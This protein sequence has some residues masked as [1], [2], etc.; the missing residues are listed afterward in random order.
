MLATASECAL[1][2]PSNQHSGIMQG[3][4]G[5]SSGKLI[6]CTRTRRA[7]KLF[8]VYGDAII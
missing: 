7:K 3:M 5:Q 4:V 6:T 1:K 8:V 2:P